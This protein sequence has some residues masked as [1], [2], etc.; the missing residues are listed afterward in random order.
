MYFANRSYTEE[1]SCVPIALIV[2]P[3]NR[4]GLENVCVPTVEILTH[5]CGRR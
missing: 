1:V 4:S 3:S 2:A 5:E